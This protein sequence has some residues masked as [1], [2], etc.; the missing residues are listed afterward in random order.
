MKELTKTSRTAGYLEKMYRQ[1][2][3]DMFNGELEECIITL[4][5]TPKSY[6]HVTDSK[7]WKLKDTNRY[8]L[9]ISADA[10]N[11]PIEN[12]VATLLHEMV[13]I[14]NIM[15]GI[16]DTSRG[17]TYH[18]KNFKTKAENVGLII[19]K[20][21]KIGWSITTPSE[22]LIDYIIDQGW[23]DIYMARNNGYQPEKSKNPNA[24]GDTEKRPSSTRKYIC[25]CCKNS[26]RAT[27]IVNI[28]CGDCHEIMQ[29]A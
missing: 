1:L 8:E 13:H 22:K 7:V 21:N 9:N 20:D 26:V 17:R 12:I 18:N 23:T 2:N 3:A 4:Q 28:I 14:Y 5:P 24:S 19:E 25:P 11:R 15:N 29:T 10:L 16:Q 6:G 27:K